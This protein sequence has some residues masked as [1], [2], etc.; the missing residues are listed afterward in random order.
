MFFWQKMSLSTKMLLSVGTALFLMLIPL[1]GWVIFSERTEIEAHAKQRALTALDMLETVHVSSMLSRIQI[2]DNDPAINALNRTMEKFSSQSDGV[3]LWLVMGKKLIAY[4]TAK[5]QSEIELPQDAADE[6]VLKT[7]QIISG[8]SSTG[9]YRMTRPVTLGEGTAGNN[10]CYGCHSRRM[11]INEGETFG[12]YSVA[13][14]LSAPLATWRQKAITQ[15]FAGAGI[16]IA[17]LG[18]IYLLLFITVIRPLNRIAGA[19]AT[20]VE[21]D[22]EIELEATER[23]D[24][25]GKLANALLVFRRNVVDNQKLEMDNFR[26]EELA[27]TAQA[28]DSL[29]SEFLANMSHEIRT[30]MNGIMGMAELLTTTELSSRQRMFADVIFNS[31][32]ALL[33]I[34]NDILDF[35]KIEAGKL[36]LDPAPFCLGAA[37]EDVATLVSGNVAEKH[38]ELIVRV[39]P[40]LA[41]NVVGDAGRIRQILTNLLGN[42]VKFTE[43][44]HVLVDVS[45]HEIEDRVKLTISVTDTGIGIPSEQLKT[46]FEKF[47]QV[48]SSSTRRHEGTGL[49]LAI[50]HRLV[51]LMSGE[52]GCE[53]TPGEGSTFWLTIELPIDKSAQGQI[54]QSAEIAGARIIAIDDNAVYRSILSERFNA[55]GLNEK[56]AASG[57]EGLAMLR[58]SVRDREPIEV[59]VLDYNMPDMTGLD[60]ARV[61]RGD[62]QLQNIAIIMLTSLNLKSENAEFK[63]LGIEAQLT[64]PARTSQLHENIVKALARSHSFQV[65]SRPSHNKQTKP[66]EIK[67]SSPK[68]TI[69]TVAKISDHPEP[70]PCQAVDTA[71]VCEETKINPKNIDENTPKNVQSGKEKSSS[72]LT[73]TAGNKTQPTPKPQSSPGSGPFIL[74]AE[75]NDINQLV[76][77]Q[78]LEHLKYNFKIVGNGKLAVEEIISSRPEIVLMDVSMPVMNGLEATREIRKLTGDGGSLAGYSPVIVGVTAHVL[79]GDR[80]KCLEA[81]M[82]DY[83]PKPVSPDML[84]R[85]VE[86]WLTKRTQRKIA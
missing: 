14:D 83:V 77:K 62:D 69:S 80:E 27:R 3:K 9:S 41:D 17:T 61:I 25:L 63:S 19:T 44:G 66:V 18:L 59:V 54:S 24:V 21:G 15:T 52:I 13:I 70:Q 78:I 32:T 47:S 71:T 73:F 57:L 29:K 5:G 45:G 43:T 42:A 1:F 4:Q 76:F 38:L 53:S 2:A 46:V 56:S 48:D 30:P 26:A 20:V 37:V 68:A 58:Q 75:D 12:A 11:G 35:S 51:G 85:K 49:G 6:E 8:I 50:T 55:W 33:T 65:G 16:V 22:I 7:G 34:I 81:G 64:K 82:D 72:F 84:A 40:D 86:K 36:E 39:Q 23:Q 79:K 67:I 31:S 60:V 74:V 10:K 28:A